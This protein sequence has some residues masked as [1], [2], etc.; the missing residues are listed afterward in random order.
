MKNYKYKVY[1]ISCAKIKYEDKKGKVHN[2]DCENAIPRDYTNNALYLKVPAELKNAKKIDFIYTI[3]EK[4]YVYHI[5][6]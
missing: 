4:Q 6:E 2:I 5:K 3:N 1:Y